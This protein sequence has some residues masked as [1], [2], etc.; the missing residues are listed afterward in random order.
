MSERWT[1]SS[2]SRPPLFFRAWALGPPSCPKNLGVSRTVLSAPGGPACRARGVDSWALEQPP[3]GSE[4]SLPGQASSWSSGS[5]SGVRRSLCQLRCLKKGDTRERETA[6]I[7]GECGHRSVAGV[8]ESVSPNVDE[9]RFL[10]SFCFVL[11]GV[12]GGLGGG[13]P[14]RLSC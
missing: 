3:R 8:R 1:H 5:R 12:V 4:W 7:K 2:P 6:E 13:V 9:V 10:P 14:R 11:L